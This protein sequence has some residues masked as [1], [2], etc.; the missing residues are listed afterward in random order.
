MKIKK[1]NWFI[2]LIIPKDYIG[3]TLYPFGIYFRDLSKV[4][5][6][7]K[8]HENIHWRQ[9]QEMY[10]LPFY[11]WYIIEWFIKLFKYWKKSY[12]NISFEREAYNNDKNK[13]YLASREPYDWLKYIFHDK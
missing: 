3:I 5:E 4:T 12:N 9:Q 10:I 1:Y 8:R 11:L 2:L 13:N 7:M 6:K